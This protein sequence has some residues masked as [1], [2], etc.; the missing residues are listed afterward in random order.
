MKSKFKELINLSDGWDYDIR[1]QKLK[2]YLKGRIAYFHLAQI[3][4][5]CIE[6]RRMI[7]S[8]T[9]VYLVIMEEC[10]GQSRIPKSIQLLRLI[11]ISIGNTRIGY[12]YDKSRLVI[13]TM[14]NDKLCKAGYVN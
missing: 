6:N 13:S 11:G 12:W 8:D 10:Q 2:N 14:S 7:K 1:K 4:R 3:K 5:L 9:Y